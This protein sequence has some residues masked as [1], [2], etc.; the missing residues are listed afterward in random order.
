MASYEQ[1]WLDNEATIALTNNTSE[2]IHNVAFLISY[3]NMKGKQ[4]D[5]KEFYY[6][7]E[8]AP[9]MT[10]SLD[11]P[12]FNHDRMYHYYKTPESL[13]NPTFKITYKLKD[14]NMTKETIAEEYP[15]YEDDSLSSNAGHIGMSI[16]VIVALFMILSIWI[17]LYVLVAVLAKNRNRSAVIWL[18]LSFVASPLLIIIILLCIGNDNRGEY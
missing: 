7:I 12:A 3:L 16:F 4:L 9:G 10:K 11:I 6:N 18:L 14:Y 13:G 1:R 2:P 17:G 8:I 5:Y 15:E